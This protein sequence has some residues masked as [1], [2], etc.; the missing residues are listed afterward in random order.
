M[1]ELDVS[2]DSETNVDVETMTKQFGP[3]MNLGPYYYVLQNPPSMIQQR[4]PFYS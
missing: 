3:V 1:N 4:C 2:D